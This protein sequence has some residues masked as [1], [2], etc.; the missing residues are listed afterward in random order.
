MEILLYI[1]PV[2]IAIISIY[3]CYDLIKTYS[4]SEREESKGVLNRKT[5][6]NTKKGYNQKGIRNER[7]KKY[8]NYKSR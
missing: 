7:N 6:K 4:I 1:V 5:F 3:F 8:R 2:I